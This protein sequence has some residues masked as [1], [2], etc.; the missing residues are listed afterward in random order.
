M[1]IYYAY[2][3]IIKQEGLVEEKFGEFT[4]I[5]FCLQKIWKICM[6]RFVLDE[7]V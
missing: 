7:N 6:S 5:E 2:V 4:T 1:C 3:D